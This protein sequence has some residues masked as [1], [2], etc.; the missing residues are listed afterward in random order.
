MK[1]L[2]IGATGLLGHEICRQLTGAGHPV[3]AL[4]RRTSDQ[5]KRAELERLG[6][7]LVEGD[8]KDQASLSRAC[9]GVQSVVSTASSTF[10]RQP[11]DSIESVDQNG[12]LALVE[13]AR[14]TGAEHLVLISFRENPN[15]QYPL[16]AANRAVER[17]L[18]A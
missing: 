1:T 2:V 12:Q 4:V 9:T 17:A 14:K 5:A 8:L 18:K 15:I 7:E 16:T 11:G 6:V 13:A 10:S 3:R